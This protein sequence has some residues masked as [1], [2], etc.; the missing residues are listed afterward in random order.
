MAILKNIKPTIKVRAPKVTIYGGPGIGKTSR[1]AEVQDLL[2]L[3]CE[4]GTDGMLISKYPVEVDENG[5]VLRDVIKTYPELIQ[6]VYDVY[7]QD[8]GFKALGIDS[9]STVEQLI[10]DQVCRE[11]GVRNIE[12]IPYGKGYKFA[13]TYWDQL[14][15][16][17]ERIRNKRNM[18]ILLLAHS[19]VKRFDDPMG[20]GYDRYRLKLH[21]TAAKTMIEWSDVVM[22]ADDKKFSTTAETGFNKTITKVTG[23]GRV[24]YTQEDPR[25]VAKNRYGLPKE[26]PLSWPAFMNAMAASYAATAAKQAQVFTQEVTQQAPIQDEPQPTETEVTQQVEP[27]LNETIEESEPTQET[28]SETQPTE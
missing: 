22:F 4:D 27:Q 8:A 5:K 21:E 2:L 13:T 23:G 12:D 7:E 18:L 16:G 3:N 1:A 26:L 14:R 15:D 11:K 10:W 25:F 24:L 28:E 20:D 9:I 17:L 19:E 6:A